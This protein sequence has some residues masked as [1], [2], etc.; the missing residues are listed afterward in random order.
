MKVECFQEGEIKTWIYRDTLRRK[1]ELAKVDYSGDSKN[2]KS[3]KL[4]KNQIFFSL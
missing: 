3:V 4:V 1:K 2:L